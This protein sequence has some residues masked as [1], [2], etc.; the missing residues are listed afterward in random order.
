MKE[1]LLLKICVGLMLT[2]MVSI[3]LNFWLY[4]SPQEGETKT[5]VNTRTE[6]KETTVKKPENKSEAIIGKVSV[7]VKYIFVPVGG[8][9]SIKKPVIDADSTDVAM[10]QLKGD[11]LEIPISQK[12]YEDS[13]YTAYISG[14]LP[15]LDSIT[16]RERI[17]YTTITNTRTVKKRPILT[18]GVTGG[19]GYG[20]KSK[21]L[22]PFVGIGLSVNVLTLF[23]K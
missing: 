5:E 10:P 11:S 18:L 8:T 22:E 7:P 6:T 21:E 3:G 4:F 19:Y 13:L 15:S 1:N 23:S 20:T 12:V 2:L 14:Y 9:D 17:I 16:V